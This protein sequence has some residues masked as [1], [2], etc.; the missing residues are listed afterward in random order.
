MAV[1]ENDQAGRRSRRRRRVVIL[2]AASTALALFAG[3]SAVRLFGLGPATYQATRIDPPGGIPFAVMDDGFF[4]YQPNKTFSYLYDPAGDLRGYLGPTGRVT[5]EINQDRMRGPSVPLE[6]SAESYRVLCLGDSFTFGE[7]VHFPDTYPARLETLL[8]QAMP[9][10]RVEVLNAGVQG[11]G[12]RFAVRFYLSYC[13]AFKPDVVTLG[14][15]LNDASDVNETVRDHVAMT[16]PPPLSSLAKVSRLWSIV[17]RSRYARRVQ[18]E[19]FETTRRSFDS[20]EWSVCKDLLRGMREAGKVEGFRFIVVVFPILWELNG[21]YPFEDIH[22]RVRSACREA[23]CEFIDLLDTYRGRR[24]ESLW[25]HPTDQHPNEIAHKLA[26]ERIA[27]QLSISPRESLR[28]ETPGVVAT[29]QSTDG[30][31]R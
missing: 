20:E 17:E 18:R 5:Y 1:D 15:F 2:A 19:Y 23:D 21:E 31:R 22:E 29:T 8:G 27:R 30:V 3:E 26:A 13:R 11:Y 6:K 10:R 24:A 4:V 28:S 9:D 14:F 12:T 25:I 16:E 7:G